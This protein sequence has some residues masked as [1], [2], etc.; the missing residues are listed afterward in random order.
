MKFIEIDVV[1][2]T[3]LAIQ[4]RTMS[5]GDEALKVRAFVSTLE[6]L[7]QSDVASCELDVSPVNAA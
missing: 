2:K 6:S 1:T 5:Y 7:R 4:T 3:L